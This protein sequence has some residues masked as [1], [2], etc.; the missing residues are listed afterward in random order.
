MKTKATVLLLAFAFLM[1][2]NLEAQVKPF[3]SQLYNLYG[4]NY[5]E[6]VDK[7][8]NNPALL[9]KAAD[10][11]A[12]HTAIGND[13]NLTRFFKQMNGF[14]DINSPYV[15][16]AEQE[17]NNFFDV[18]DNIDDVLALSG[19]VNNEYTGRLVTGE[20]SAPDDVDVYEFTVDTTMMY[21]FAGLHGTNADGSEM[22]V[23]MRLFHESDLD[24]T[25]QEDF[26]GISGNEQIR[27]DILGRD[28]DGRGGAGLFRLTGWTSP[29]DA[30]TGRQITGRF[31]LWVF[32][33]DGNVG[34]YNMTAY[35]VPLDA[36]KDKAEPNY[37]YDNLVINSLDPLFVIPTDGVVRT[38]M[39]Y[40]DT[41]KVVEPALPSQSN[42]TYD[43]LLAEG[44]EDVDLFFM[45]YEEGKTL[46]V[47]TL[48][49][50]GFYRE[51]DGSIGGGSSR[52]SDPRI[53]VYKGDGI[54]FANRIA[55][56][57]DGARER[58][59]GPNNIHSR[60]VLSPED[61]AASGITTDE[62]LVLWVAAW[63][64]QERVRT[65]DDPNNDVRNVDN[66]DPGRMMYDL[67]AYQYDADNPDEVEP[68]DQ[69]SQATVIAARADTVAN[70]AF[71]SGSDVDMFR[72]F[73]HE[74]RMYSLFSA[75]V[76][77]GAAV[78]IEI[79]HETEAAAFDGTT[80][81]SND[82]L[83]ANSIP[84]QTN[85]NNFQINGFVPE[86]SGAYIIRLSSSAAGSYQLGVIDKGEIY[87]GRIS[88]EPDNTLADATTQD[89]LQIGAGAAALTSM[90]F[91]A[92][93]VDHYYFNTDQDFTITLRG[94]QDDLVRDFSGTLTLL[95]GALSELAS[96]S[97]GVLSFSPSG[98]TDFVVRVE[99][100]N[101]GDVGFYVISGGEPFE[102]DEPNDSFANATPIVLGEL[103]EA[104]LTAGDTDYF[105]VVLKKGSLYSFRGVDNNTGSELAV[106]FYDQVDGTTL[107]D[108][109]GWPDNY[110]GN[111]KI[112]NIIPQETRTYYLRISGNAGDYK[113]LSRENDQFFA[114][115][116][117]HEPDNSIAEAAA[118]GSYVMDG[119]D[120]MFVQ[121][122]ADSARFFGDLDYFELDVKAGMRVVAETKPVAGTTASSGDPDLW[123]QDND[124]RLRLFDSEG[125]LVDDNDDDDGGN[126]WY[127]KIEYT[128]GADAKLYLQVANSRGEGGGDD[129]S[130]RRGDY[131]LNVAASFE[132][133]ESNDTFADAVN[134]PLADGGFVN[135]TFATDADVDMYALSLE[136]GNIYHI[137]TTKEEG[138]DASIGAELYADGATTTN[139]LA[140]GSSF[141]TRYS[142]S[143]IK[144]NFIPETSGT[145]F[146]QL[147]APAASVDRP[148]RVYMKSNEIAPLSSSW[149]PN[150]TI[151]EAAA[152][153]DH[154]SD[155]LFYEYML[156]DATVEGFH[157]DL[158]YYQ[159]TAEAGDTLIGE[160]A[161][162]DGELWPR[163]FDSYMYLYDAQGTELAAN[164]DGGFDW[165]SRIEY[166]VPADGTYYFLVVGQDAYVPPRNDDSNRIRDPARG[167]YT[168]S[169]TRLNGNVINSN[170]E[171]VLVQEYRLDQN[172]PNPFNPTTNIR[173][174]IAN[175]GT[176]TLEVF[177]ILGQ[178]VAT[179][180]N[181]RQSAGTY[182]VQ[183]DARSLASGMYVYRLT[184]GDYVQT[185]KLMLIK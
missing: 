169:I 184:S 11:H 103:Y 130:M 96:S 175:Q 41:V 10:E 152:R 133:T 126:G 3:D 151:A 97:N 156:Y 102:E 48:P 34:T 149:E 104:A 106:E 62:S 37:P 107:L 86:E 15:G 95:D 182:T 73:L 94:T 53:R 162:F 108:D 5:E 47:E 157:D 111:F 136:A 55:E 63:A 110:D 45:D 140:D 27:G 22:S 177:N 78:N 185:K 165:H 101:A 105:S 31:Y 99:A 91:P 90:I 9:Q 79:F 118:R 68:N 109:S 124:T 150:N 100:G 77:L 88:N 36:F 181:Q 71:A 119:V 25:V 56:D 138:D 80:D 8:G 66:R 83:A 50:F 173:Y 20:F 121:F 65:D 127:S 7:F 172:Y 114:L 89:P 38:F 59:D 64:S 142:G 164:D 69:V 115:E 112:A 26:L 120:R 70:G 139:L 13:R 49:Y 1:S 6:V 18:A 163:D 179:L 143:N 147:N 116:S 159:V 170:E 84:V 92:N 44:D 137:R 178:K 72:V 30:E 129:R 128:A 125:A 67:Y 54:Q 154:P 75:D 85:G 123:N 29:I 81:L 40:S 132:E 153:G 180:V 74:H 155:G 42:Q 14:V 117:K 46:V 12:L 148:Y 82:I 61:F 58:M 57:D 52:M 141:N 134:N 24:T 17:D 135:A 28:T 176:V 113:I 32:N 98:A 4:S 166:V 2:A 23:S 167:E 174:A 93:D 183:F 122:N 19:V 51:N 76:S 158:D 144:I 161:P 21:Y 16:R 87:G 160:G 39:L 168:F 43:Q 35:Q 171:E 60:I 33:E 131:I 146:L 145:Y